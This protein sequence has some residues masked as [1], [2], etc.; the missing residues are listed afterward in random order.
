MDE[1]LPHS[2]ANPFWEDFSLCVVM[3]LG[4]SGALQYCLAAGSLVLLTSCGP[5]AGFPISHHG[6][7]GHAARSCCQHPL[8]ALTPL[9][10]PVTKL[11][12]RL[13]LCPGHSPQ[14]S[15]SDGLV[16]SLKQG[17]LHITLPGSWESGSPLAAGFYCCSVKDQ[18]VST[19]S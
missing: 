10:P 16:F 2:F 13:C 1:F 5:A 4:L 15:S 18:L 3:S 19:H 17:L 12:S 11:L 6:G 9:C 14:D 7:A 8:V